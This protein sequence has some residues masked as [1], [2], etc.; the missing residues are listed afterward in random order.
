MYK[1]LNE[2]FMALNVFLKDFILNSFT[3][4]TV[5]IV[6]FD[7]DIKRPLSSFQIGQVM[8][9]SSL[10]FAQISSSLI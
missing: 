2:Y 4:K 3:S 7:L 5:F 1:F 8:A 10:F 9:N 6:K